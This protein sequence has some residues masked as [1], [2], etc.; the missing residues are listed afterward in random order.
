MEDPT[1]EPVYPRA[2][3]SMPS[4]RKLLDILSVKSW[5]GGVVSLSIKNA[6]K[7]LTV[8]VHDAVEITCANFFEICSKIELDHNVLGC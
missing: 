5:G 6:V 1:S 4:H 3:K 8:C 2:S 7:F